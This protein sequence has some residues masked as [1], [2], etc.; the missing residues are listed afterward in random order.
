MR[1]A[2]VSLFEAHPFLFLFVMLM[3]TVVVLPLALD[4]LL[5]G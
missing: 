1:E 2:L 3:L 4:K 5:N